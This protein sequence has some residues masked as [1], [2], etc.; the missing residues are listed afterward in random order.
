MALRSGRA[1][2][3]AE[4]PLNALEELGDQLSLYARAIAWTPRTLRRYRGEIGRLLAEVSFGSGAL[5]VILGTA[6]VMLSLS[7]FVGS[8]VGL[9]GFRALD[10]LGVEALTGFITAY[11]NTRDI[12][13]LVAA[14]AL[15][16]TLGA[17]FT[18]QLGAMRISEEID[19][20]EVMAVP[21]VP[22][23]IT[24]RVIAGVIAIIPMYTIGLLASFVA[25][26][27]NVTVINQLPGGT[28]DHY[29]NLFLPVSDVLYSY[30]KV[31]VFAIMVILIH[32]HYGYTARGGPSGVGIAVGR[33]V[34]LSIV[35]TAIMDFF[36]T[37]VLYGTETS[38]RVSG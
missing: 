30:L 19:A 35:S 27:L 32:C 37:L 34:R 24:T 17:G 21:S 38:V 26:R 1:R 14:A 3:L 9:Q 11:F 4:V 2:R 22:F 8:L 23:L 29:F 13:P 18:A 16:A 36:L 15:T 31:I 5:I 7:L 33:S 25:S 28:Y 12:A 6:G 10:S 20:L